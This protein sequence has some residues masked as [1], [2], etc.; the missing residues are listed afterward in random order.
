MEEYILLRDKSQLSAYSHMIPKW[1]LE[2]PKEEANMQFVGASD[3]DKPSG[4][5]V[6]SSEA[7]TQTQQYL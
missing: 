5:A 1:L 4:V 2:S 3:F 7:G 6:M